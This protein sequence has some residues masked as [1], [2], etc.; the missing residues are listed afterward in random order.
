MGIM[1]FFRD[2]RHRYGT[3]DIAFLYH[4]GGKEINNFNQLLEHLSLKHST[5]ILG[6]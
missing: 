1:V 2:Y 5:Y 6:R 4:I 3:G